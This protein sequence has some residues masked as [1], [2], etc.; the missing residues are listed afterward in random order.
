[1]MRR[2]MMFRIFLAMFLACGATYADEARVKGLIRDWSPLVWLAPG[3]RFLPLG[4]PEFLDNVEVDDNY[5][6]T[7]LS[8]QSL[9]QNRSSFLHGR[10]PAGNVPIYALVKNCM[11]DH[12]PATE[13]SAT[14]TTKGTKKPDLIVEEFLFKPVETNNVPSGGECADFFFHFFK[15]IGRI[16][17]VPPPAMSAPP[18]KARLS[19]KPHDLDETKRR[20]LKLQQQH[21]QKPQRPPLHFHVTYWMFYPYSEGK[22]VCVLDLGFLGSWPIPNIGGMCLGVLKE[23]GSHVGDWEHVS[24]YF[25]GKDHPV[26]MYVSAHDAGA[27]YRYEALSGTFVYE[28]Q[29]TRK[30][31]LFQK[32]TFPERVFTSQGSHPVL[33]SARGSH[34]LWTAPGKHKFVRL[35]RLYDESGF[36]T[37]W[38]T[39]RK[40][41]LLWD[42]ES[43][44]MPGWMTFTGKWGN[45]K[46]NCHPLA[47]FGFNICEFVDGPTGIPMK[48]MNFKC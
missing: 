38:P 36:G 4:V 23:Y 28:S 2:L 3:E 7:R 41:E 24:L 30:G 11:A 29:E 13:S 22:A 25:K 35:P 34:G 21:K 17:E 47:R 20:K 32:P 14:S 33:F 18:P 39:W 26:A 45:P 42:W 40:L 44:A 12:S 19:P 46:S 1:M 5:L 43:N 31:G 8:L 48:R 9:L 10:K 6:R 27:F 37:P 15:V 16:L